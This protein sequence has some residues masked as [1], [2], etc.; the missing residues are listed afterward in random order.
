MKADAMMTL[1][2]NIFKYDETR[3]HNP[4]GYATQIVKYCFITFLEKEEIV[5]D[6]KDSLW[7]SIGMTPSYARQIRNEMMKDMIDQSAK[8]LKAVKKDVE[9][10]NLKIQALGSIG[11][12]LN[13]AKMPDLEL[14]FEIAETLEMDHL[15]YTGDLESTLLL[16]VD[17][18]SYTVQ[19]ITVDGTDKNCLSVYDASTR[20]STKR[21]L[22]STDHEAIV[23]ALCSIGLSVRRDLL[24]KR[25]RELSGYNL[26]TTRIPTAERMLPAD[27]P[28]EETADYQAPAKNRRKNRKK[29]P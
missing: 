13:R 10:L 6:I 7:E 18:P 5:R 19:R 4:F 26:T 28:L 11:S 14:D 17:P 9:I 27:D 25:L 29:D 1:C 23:V 2:Q 3:F 20:S 15:P 21:V 22:N 12:R 8:G 16:F 24:V